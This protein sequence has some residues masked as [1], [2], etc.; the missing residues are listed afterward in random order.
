MI[1][2]NVIE[3]IALTMR[4]LL[5][6]L[7]FTKIVNVSLVI[8]HLPTDIYWY[9]VVNAVNLYAVSC[10]EEEAYSFCF[11]ESVAKIIYGFFH[12]VACD[13]CALNDFKSECLEFLAHQ[14]CVVCGV[15]QRRNVCSVGTVAD[16]E[17]NALLVADCVR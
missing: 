6:L 11:P 2:Y 3:S 14:L 5:L 4:A 9:E 16:Y 15:F 13:V 12:L 10:I 8:K 17:G 7:A 1:L